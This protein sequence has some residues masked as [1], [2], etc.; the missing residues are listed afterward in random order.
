MGH[1]LIKKKSKLHEMEVGDQIPESDFGCV[2]ADQ[3]V[4]LE[5]V[6]ET[7]KA[8][9]YKVNPGIW[10]IVKDGGRLVLRATEFTHDKILESFVHT[11][12]ITKRVDKFFERKHIYQQFGVEIP[13]RTILLWGPA[14]TGKTQ[15]LIK[16]AEKY[17]QKGNFAIIIWKT[18]VIDPYE[19]KEFVKTFQYEGVE[20]LIV[21]AEDIG[22][23]EIDQVRIKSESSL[24]SLLDNQEKAF[25]IPVLIVATTNYPENL[26]ANLTNRPQRIDDKIEVGYP[27]PKERK[28]LFRFFAGERRLKRFLYDM[29]AGDKCKNFTPSHIKEIFV[30][31]AIYGISLRKS[32]I[33]L[34]EEIERFNNLFQNKVK[35]GIAVKSDYDYD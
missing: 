27:T 29:I 8:E 22:G 23:V 3:F 19:V 25:T 24:L 26:L 7:N 18:D 15:S 33:Q 35:M 30:R 1:F 5:Y 10:M 31:S 6:E 13:R 21:I 28:A 9:P 14:G 16:I 17:N 11:Q 34:Q 2:S 12:E 20:N 32:I 4:Q